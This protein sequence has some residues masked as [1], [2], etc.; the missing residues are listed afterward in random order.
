MEVIPLSNNYSALFKIV[1][2]GE[3]Y[4]FRTLYNSR[5]GNWSFDIIKNNVEFITGINMV[6]GTD[7]IG[8][9]NLGIGV[10]FM[11]DLESFNLDAT[12]FDIGERV[13]LVHTTEEE[14]QNAL[15]V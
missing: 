15:T 9:F 13:V 5:F 14:I 11:A 6:L 10:L 3:T 8:Q 2:N 12:A 1:L 7:I 4:D